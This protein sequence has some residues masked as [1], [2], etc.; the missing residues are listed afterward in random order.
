MKLF[1]RLL[2][3]LFVI[4]IIVFSTNNKDLVNVDLWPFELVSLP[5]WALAWIGIVIG[6]TLGFIVSWFAGGKVRARARDLHR[7]LETDRREMAALSKRAEKAEAANQQP[8]IPLPPAD[9]A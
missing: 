4:V 7:R 2:A 8:R 1:L 5:V 9:A 6:L 3:L